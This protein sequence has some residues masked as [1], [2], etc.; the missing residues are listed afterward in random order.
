MLHRKTALVLVAVLA[1][2]AAGCSDDEESSDGT[3]SSSAESTSTTAAPESA[4]LDVT[5]T[6]YAYD[7]GSTEV[8]AGAVEINLSNEGEEEHQ[9]TVV[10]FKEG[11]SVAD[12]AVTEEDPTQLY[13]VLETFGGPSAV[14]PG[15]SVRAVVDLEPGSYTVICFIPSPSDGVSHA[16]KGMIAELEVTE[17]AEPAALPTAD[18]TVGLADFEFQLPDGFT[19]S[20]SVEV[21]NDGPQAHE[22]AAYRVA[23][24]KTADDVVAFLSVPPGSPPPEGPPPFEP[25]AGISALDSGVTNVVDLNLTPGNYVLLCFLPDANDGLPH[26]LKGMVQPVTIS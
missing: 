1:L 7:M 8:P 12:L 22:L 25:A 17:A 18:E 3:T 4:S 13:D 6:D 14:G 21:R 19:G 26:F 11:K 5:A 9:V 16:A 23:E 10:R 24:G 15:G 20:S 2:L